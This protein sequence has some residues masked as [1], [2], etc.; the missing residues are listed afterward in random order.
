MDRPK[1]ADGLKNADGP[2]AVLF[3][4]RDFAPG[5]ASF[6][7]RPDV[8]VPFVPGQFT[9]L[10]LPT[11]DHGSQ[12]VQHAYSFASAPNSDAYEFLVRLVPGGALTPRLFDLE[13][14]QRLWVEPRVHGK[15]TLDAAPDSDELVLVGTGTGVAPFRSMLV[16]GSV[17]DRF[18]R[19]VLVHGARYVHDLA[20]REEFAQMAEVDADFEYLA[21]VTVEPD[22]AGVELDG[23][24]RG[25]VLRLLEP[26]R[27]RS[28]TGRD[29]VPERCQ[30]F[31]CGNPAMI[32][33]ATLL[34]EERGF[35]KHRTRHPGH[36]HS[37]RFW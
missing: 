7:V 1:N 8:P 24:H 13:V 2:N 35:R 14:G 27:Y 37:E 5:L 12:F 15:F 3:E 19:V 30:V 20:Y 21:T 11:D 23:L 4:R 22:D 33:D 34:L 29:L 32:A 26:D 31:L 17:H 28:V 36:I 10:G 25:R 6:F 16:H 9:R 18:R